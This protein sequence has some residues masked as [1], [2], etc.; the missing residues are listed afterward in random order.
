MLS[1]VSDIGGL[2]SCFL[3]RT[4]ITSDEPLLSSVRI[5]CV[6]EVNA[7]LVHTLLCR[8]LRRMDQDM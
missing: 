4:L 5:K 7:V 3:P 8:C 1:S 2:P 6:I